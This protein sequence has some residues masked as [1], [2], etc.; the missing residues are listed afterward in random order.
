MDLIAQCDECLGYPRPW[1]TGIDDTTTYV[2][3]N[4]IQHAEDEYPIFLQANNVD[5]NTPIAISELSTSV[6]TRYQYFEALVSH[7]L[8]V[9]FE[10]LLRV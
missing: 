2:T 1:C 3:Q 7:Y 10:V 5:V 6:S 8:I 4:S 9:S